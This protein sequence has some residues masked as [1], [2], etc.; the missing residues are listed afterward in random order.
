MSEWDKG[1]VCDVCHQVHRQIS[2]A[3]NERRRAREYMESEEGKMALRE[4]A[5]RAIATMKQR[6]RA[7]AEVVEREAAFSRWLDEDGTWH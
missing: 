3:C 2:P 6:E 1:H 5:E 7:R 4:A